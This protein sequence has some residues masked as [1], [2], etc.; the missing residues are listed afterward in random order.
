M[1]WPRPSAC[2][3]GDLAAGGECGHGLPDVAEGEPVNLCAALNVG[4]GSEGEVEN[5]SR[6]QALGPSDLTLSA[7]PQA[8]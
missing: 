1:G 4:G 8:V 3:H 5:D 7:R 2:G 6:L